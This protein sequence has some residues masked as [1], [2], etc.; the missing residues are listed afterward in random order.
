MNHDLVAKLSVYDDFNDSFLGQNE[1]IEKKYVMYIIIN[2]GLKMQKGKIASQVG[3]AVH[4]I[5]Q[6][7]VINKLELWQNYIYNKCPKIVLK[8]ENQEQ[9]LEII[10][11]TKHIYKSYIIDEGKTQIPPNSLTAIG[12]IPLCEDDIPECLKSLK[13]L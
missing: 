4:K 8:T 3:H 12:Y 5:T 6:H 1:S 13:L 2:G 10:E 7:C 9:L 11:N